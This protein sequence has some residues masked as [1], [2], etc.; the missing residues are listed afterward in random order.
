MLESREDWLARTHAHSVLAVNASR[1]AETLLQARLSAERPAKSTSDAWQQSERRAESLR[2]QI[3]AQ[4]QETQRCV[5][6]QE[7]A[8]AALA[9]AHRRVEILKKASER[10]R[11]GVIKA[12]GKADARE[13]DGLAL[14]RF[15]QAL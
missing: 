7:A 10:L 9:T 5:E 13:Q 14:L 6:Q 4:Q 8:Q 2:Q 12:R 1:E 11:A 15:Q 3:L